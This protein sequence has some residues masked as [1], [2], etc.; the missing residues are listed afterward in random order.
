MQKNY[1][2]HRLSDF[3]CLADDDFQ[4][5]RSLGSGPIELPRNAVLRAE[6]STDRSMYL[7][8]DGWVLSSMLLRNGERQILKLHLPGDWLGTSSMAVERAVDTLTALTPVTVRKVPLETL[9]QLMASSPRLMAF[10]MLTSQKERIA[11]M[12]RL[13][14][15]GRSTA[16]ARLA[17]FLLDLNLRLE[18]VGQAQEGRFELRI[19]QEQL[20]DMLGLTAVHV[21][22][23]VREMER[24]GLIERNG[25][26][27][28]LADMAGLN[29]IAALPP[30]KTA[31]DTAWI[32]LD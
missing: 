14:T 22:R 19:T 6:S 16:I 12:D 15:V 32:G 23:M 31:A 27:V 10:T 24:R 28:R 13:A 4:R 5:M 20:G 21:N 11:L 26:T 9:G 7:L 25:M 8:V 2:D 3:A 30:R 29:A 17:S 18:R 1:P